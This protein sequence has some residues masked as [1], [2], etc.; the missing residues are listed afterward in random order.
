M[1]MPA[2]VLGQFAMC[3]QM[4]RLQCLAFGPFPDVI[5]AH[6]QRRARSVYGSWHFNKF[7]VQSQLDHNLGGKT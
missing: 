6:A 4:P 3:S 1:F 7:T 2:P 5:A